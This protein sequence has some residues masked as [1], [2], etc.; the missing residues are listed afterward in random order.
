M[1]FQSDDGSREFFAKRGHGARASWMPH[2]SAVVNGRCACVSVGHE[3]KGPKDKDVKPV[4]C[5]VF[6]RWWKPCMV[7]FVGGRRVV[8]WNW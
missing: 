4:K 2:G 8:S 3:A 6:V 1:Q 7:V 5:S